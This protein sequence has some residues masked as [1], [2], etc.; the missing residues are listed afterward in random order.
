MEL[1]PALKAIR[2]RGCK[3]VGIQYPD[4]LR[5]RALEVAEEL[6]RGAG[7]TAMVSAQPTFGACDVPRMPVDLVVQIGHA[8][9]PYLNL[10]KVVFVEAPMAL[11]SLDFLDPALPLLGSRVGLL[12]NVQHRPW[13]SDVVTYL[14]E[15]GK[16]VLVGGPD[17][18]TA[19]DG[20]LLGC[21]VHPA[22]EV[23]A[24]VDAFLYVGTGVF[25]PLG[26][27]LATETLVIAADPFTEE[28]LDLAEVKDRVLRQRHAAVAL[29]QEA[30][31]FGIIVSRKVGQYRMALARKAKE[32]LESH[33]RKGYL[34]L[35]DEVRPGFLQGYRVDAFVNTAC[36]RIAI[37][38]AA[39]YEKPMLTYPELE[40]ALG[41]RS[42]DPYPLDEITAERNLG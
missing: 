9:M 4:G 3:T 11:P 15:R 1:E 39:Q 18:R 27:A 31:A 34:L 5:L 41:V 20:Q 30:E 8:P 13:L 42:W 10:Q 23:E 21:D 14:Q 40:V 28:V 26:V 29:A 38:D 17:G 25:H 2:D 37:D 36:P 35:M 22:R 32:L 12:T 6:E 16:E 7:V 33:G 24:R 19:Y